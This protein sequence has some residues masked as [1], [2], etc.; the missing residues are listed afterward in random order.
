MEIPGNGEAESQGTAVIAAI[1]SHFTEACL[2][3][4]QGES[5]ILLTGPTTHGQA[6]EVIGLMHYQPTTNQDAAILSDLFLYRNNPDSEGVNFEAPDG[7]VINVEYFLIDQISFM[8]EEAAEVAKTNK[9]GAAGSEDEDVCDLRKVYLIDENGDV[10]DANYHQ[11]LDVGEKT[12][13]AA[14]ITE[15]KLQNIPMA[16]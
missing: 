6:T 5:G 7:S 10:F 14:K 15:A 9:N 11:L 16:S 12:A 4:L 3:H 13:L 1:D 2:R 8:H